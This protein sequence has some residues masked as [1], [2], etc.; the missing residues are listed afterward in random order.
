VVLPLGDLEKTRIVPYVTYGLIVLN[1]LV[2]LFQLDSSRSLEVAY[3]ATPFE[4]THQV[5]LQEP[6][7][8]EISDP[9]QPGE[10]VIRT[11]PEAPGPHPIWLT[12][13]TSMFLHGSPLHLAGNMLFL[14][15][16]GD[17]VEEVLGRVV[18]LLAYLACGLIGSIA[19][20]AVEPD[21]FVPILGASGAIAGVMG[22]YLVW[23]PHNRVRVL[24][25]QFI[26]VL[27]A[28]LVI[29]LW[30]A[31]QIWWGF[32]SIRHHP[33]ASG[34]AYLAHIGGAGTG[35]IIAFFFRDRAERLRAR[36]L[37]LD[38]WFYGPP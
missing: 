35:V 6:F 5:D 15:I 25:F 17:N 10:L 14:W 38:G 24:V 37:E 4:I 28:V 16:F 12:L 31:I 1:L 29:G 21:S 8:V 18:Y 27:P 13:F 23:F 2:Y 9:R 36:N 19:Q 33:G 34:V 20:I 7:D 32:G 22:M 3:A 30:I 26:T 11:V